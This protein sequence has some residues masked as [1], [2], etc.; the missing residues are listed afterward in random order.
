MVLGAYSSA[1]LLN[2]QRDSGRVLQRRI[3]CARGG[4]RDG[5]G[6]GLRGLCEEPAGAASG[7][8]RNC[9]ASDKHKKDA[10]ECARRLGELRADAPTPQ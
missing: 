1:T 6:V 8:P 3:C 9:G 2:C 4:C 10:E 5:N 7:Q